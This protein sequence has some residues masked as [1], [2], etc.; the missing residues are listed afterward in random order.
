ME[1]ITVDGEYWRVSFTK[2]VFVVGDVRLYTSCGDG[3]LVQR[4]GRALGSRFLLFDHAP[5]RA[6]YNDATIVRALHFEEAHYAIRDLEGR[7]AVLEPMKWV[8]FPSPLVPTMADCV[9]EAYD[10][11]VSDVDSIR[12]DTI[13]RTNPSET[14]GRPAIRV[15]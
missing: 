3:E 15:V 7:D 8:G 6:N 9:Y 12:A 14:D 4:L 2:P 10:E 5:R 13:A 11:D 1:G